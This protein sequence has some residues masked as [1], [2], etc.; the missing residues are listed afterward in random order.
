MV[1][2][3]YAGGG[4]GAVYVGASHRPTHFARPCGIRTG[5]GFRRWFRLGA[6]PQETRQGQFPHSPYDHPT[7]HA[8][9]GRTFGDADVPCNAL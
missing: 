3:G 8:G 4:R 1:A 9:Q 5:R 7:A 6:Q 2:S